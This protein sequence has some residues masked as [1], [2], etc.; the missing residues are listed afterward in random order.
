LIL[1]IWT[2]RSID[3]AAG[4]AGV[5]NW[6]GGGGRPRGG[7]PK[8]LARPGFWA[9]YRTGGID[10]ITG[11]CSTTVRRSARAAKMT[12]ALASIQIWMATTS[13][14]KTTGGMSSMVVAI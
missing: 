8:G 5:V 11:C 12:M 3:G 6:G 1:W 9:N 14:T 4:A 7:R 2:N 13:L 10:Y